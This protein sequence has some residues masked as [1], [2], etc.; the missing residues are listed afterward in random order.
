[1]WSITS[2]K[3]QILMDG[4]EVHYSANRVGLLDF[5]WTMVGNH[6]LK[7]VCHAAPPLSPTP[8]FRQ[9]D[10]FIDGQ[11][12]FSMPKVFELGVKGASADDNR[13][14]GHHPGNFSAAVSP[15]SVFSEAAGGYGNAY[16]GPVRAPRTQSE[17]DEYLQ[18]AIQASLEE[19]KTHSGEQP[20]VVTST[21]SAEM[22]LLDFGGGEEPTAYD[23]YGAPPAPAYNAPP[24]AAYG[25]PSSS[26]AGSSYGAA[27]AAAA[28]YGA[29]TTNG[30]GPPAA[31][32]GALTAG[33]G[34]GPAPAYAS[35][36]APAGPPQPM[37]ALPPSSTGGYAG[38][39]PPTDQYSAGQPSYGAPPPP[40]AQ[41][42]Y[43]AAPAPYYG[44]PP[45]GSYG[46]PPAYGVPPAYGAPPSTPTSY[47]GS[48]PPGSYPDP[49]APSAGHSAGDPFAPRTP[50]HN[51]VASDI[52]KAYGS[53]PSPGQYQPGYPGSNG[54]VYQSPQGS[55]APPTT[56][57]SMSMSAL[58]I[59]EK[60]EEKPLNPFEAAMKKLV[61]VDH[62]DE[63]AEEQMKLSIKKEEENRAVKNK[64]RSVPLPPAGKKV[65]GSAATLKDIAKVKP[66]PRMEPVIKPAF[67]VDPNMAGALTV[68][69]QGPPPLQ[70]QG[71]GVVHMQG[72]VPSAYYGGSPQ[73]R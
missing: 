38:G 54:T 12:F 22:D 39:P 62:I 73:Y 52:L 48:P 58:T 71:F 47:G 33:Y 9:Y 68:Y 6:V 40:P 16:N 10:F 57:M 53:T 23:A 64:N 35:S 19:T 11:S 69:G 34:A 65:L 1:V 14:P 26:Y 67:N 20:S 17:D 44:A 45:A 24:T 43:G 36:Y 27:P 29:P 61:N 46:A 4:R 56:P 42:S 15:R 3:R 30:Y 50:S 37:L 70:P 21:P 66:P 7:T 59:T 31:Y 49:F 28:A 51:N 63:P 32:G 55:S 18:K 2:G 5:S 8:G 60:E 25:D 41:S 13:I 72:R